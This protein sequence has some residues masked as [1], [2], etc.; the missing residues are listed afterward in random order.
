MYCNDPGGDWNPGRGDN[1]RYESFCH[2]HKRPLINLNWGQG[3]DGDPEVGVLLA[4]CFRERARTISSIS[5]VD[6]FGGPYF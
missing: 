3:R 6:F 4:I 5:V 1:P 2:V